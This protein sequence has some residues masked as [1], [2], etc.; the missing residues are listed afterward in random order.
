MKKGFMH[1]VELVVISLLMI[2]VVYQLYRNVPSESFW[3]R[4]QLSTLSGDI[5]HSLDAKGVSWTDTGQV[6]AEL[7][8]LLGRTNIIFDIE[9]QNLPKPDLWVGCIC[10]E[11]EYGEYSGALTGT[12]TLNGMDYRIRME[13]ISPQQPEFP[14]IY[15]VIIIGKDPEMLEGYQRSLEKY[16]LAGRGVIEIRDFDQP[17]VSND[18][19]QLNIFG[20]EWDAGAVDPGVPTYKIEFNTPPES[21]YYNIRKYFLAIPNVSGNPDSID[22]FIN[23]TFLFSNFLTSEERLWPHD[24]ND[25]R[26]VLWV[27]GII[28][29]SPALIVR[30]KVFKGKGRTAW[31]S[32][33]YQGGE[34]EEN[35][36]LIKSLI[37]WTSGETFHITGHEIKNPETS[38]LIDVLKRSRIAYKNPTIDELV[39]QKKTFFHPLKI[40]LLLGYVLK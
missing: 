27:R 8:R 7:I 38:Y 40:V 11:P 14:L 28:P 26:A 19:A 32:A 22:D 13:R 17:H 31:L 35:A 1:I 4:A 36:V 18:D 20:L 39:E 34:G 37:L 9:I 2:L 29:R 21:R 6:E 24:N 16:L 12:F 25:E 23:E 10:T 30:D 15:D 33:G 5:L 3:D